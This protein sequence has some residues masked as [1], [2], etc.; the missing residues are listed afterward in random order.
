M[1]ELPPTVDLVPLVEEQI[2][3]LQ[4][5]PLDAAVES[6]HALE[7]RT[8]VAKDGAANALVC[9][10]I[11]TRCISESRWSDLGTNI[12]V[13]AK[14]RGFF[15]KAISDSISLAMEA[16]DQISDPATKLTL[17]R[18]LHEVT[19]GK[20]F[21]EVERARLTRILVVDLEAKGDLV[22][23]MNM[24]QD[25]RLEILT[26]MDTNERQSLML[27]QFRLCLEANDTLRATLSAEKISDQKFPDDQIRLE[28]LHLLVRYH[29]T[30]TKEYLPLAE[31]WFAI[32]ELSNDGKALI[33]AIINGVLAGNSQKQVA[34][35]RKLRALKDI[36]LFPEGRA[37]LSVFLGQDLVPWAEFAPK[38]AVIIPD[39][40]GELMRKRVIEHSL[41][42]VASYYTRIRLQRL[43]ELE[44]ITL[45]ELESR[46]IDLVF[47]DEFY[48][49]IDRP[50]GVITFQRKQK[51]A[52]VGD[53]FS[54][55]LVKLCRLVDHTHALIEKE[56]QGISRN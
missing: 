42:V 13:I 12:T 24:L 46:I 40:E 26:T 22:T 43:A 52:E 34:F 53:E 47:N 21:L 44:Q 54:S 5:A 9:R 17:V 27:V 30:F 7:R 25:L 50:K 20:I 49:K 6:L 4:S 51:E 28:F 36:S 31:S 3:L 10:E 1:A 33:N 29:S 16:L 15:R 2:T 32:Y 18:V 55:N 39:N 23:A 14:R 8:R 11:I 48:A 35:L 37:I 19:S 38:F 41:R 45:D 56:L